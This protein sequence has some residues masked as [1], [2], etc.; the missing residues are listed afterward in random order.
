[1]KYLNLFKKII[2]IIHYLIICKINKNNLIKYLM[3]FNTREFSFNI[4]K[5]TR[6]GGCKSTTFH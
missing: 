3:E 4:N 1:L 5:I 2:I 6:N